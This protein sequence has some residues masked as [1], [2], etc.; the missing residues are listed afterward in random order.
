M[1]RKKVYLDDVFRLIAGHSDYHG[2]NI[3]AALTC[4]AEG[5]EVKPIRPL[6]R[7]VAKWEKHP[8]RLFE[9]EYYTCSNCGSR[10]G[11]A[12]SFRYCFNCGAEM[13]G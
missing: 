13:E 7:P 12:I 8:K 11:L 4:V 6:E 2:D 3:L 1:D 5:K 10:N 9:K